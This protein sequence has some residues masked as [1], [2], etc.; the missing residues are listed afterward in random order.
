MTNLL[1]HP[2]VREPNSSVVLDFYLIWRRQLW[3]T[4][5]I[6]TWRA[7][8]RT[9]SATKQF[10]LGALLT[11]LVLLLPPIAHAR[12][13]QAFDTNVPFK[14]NIGSR[15]FRPGNY[16]FILVGPGLLSLCDEK[17]HI[18]ASLMTRSVET[19][20]LSPAS[21]AIFR[22]EKKHPRLVE[23]RIQDRSEVLEIVGEEVTV[24]R[25]L[26]PGLTPDVNSL[27]ER[28]SS[29]GMKQ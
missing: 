9:C 21:K 7:I 24:H 11:V 16:K 12:T 8:K 13:Y 22:T 29:P 18:V 5:A 28:R 19:G 25:A 26:Q 4:V 15:T 20:N 17:G 23:L 2:E 1:P 27:F 10:S 3:K 14:F 6:R